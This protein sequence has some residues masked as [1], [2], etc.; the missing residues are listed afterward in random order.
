LACWSPQAC[1]AQ[2]SARSAGEFETAGHV[3]V[4]LV[5]VD[6]QAHADVGARA[7][8]PQRGDDAVEFH[9]QVTQF[10]GHAAGG[11]DGE[12]Q[13]ECFRRATG[14]RAGRC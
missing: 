10:I 1:L 12:Q 8:A 3:L 11:V 4:A 5:A 2:A 6:H 9:L 14:R 7:D 13:V